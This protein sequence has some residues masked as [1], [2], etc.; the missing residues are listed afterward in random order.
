MEDD[1]GLLEWLENI[2]GHVSICYSTSL[3]LMSVQYEWGFCFVKGVP[4]TPEATEELLKRIAFVRPTHY[5]TNPRL[6]TC[7]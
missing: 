7:T 1:H 2:V 4:T 6:N 3:L 5:G